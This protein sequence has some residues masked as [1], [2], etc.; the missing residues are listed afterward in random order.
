MSFVRNLLKQ[1]SQR[2]KR[3]LNK[4]RVPLVSLHREIPY[5]NK[6]IIDVDADENVIDL[7]YDEVAATMLREGI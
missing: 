7:A 4:I 1:I 2:I 6:S 5:I 3:T